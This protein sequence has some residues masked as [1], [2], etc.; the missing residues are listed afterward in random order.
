MIIA[1]P[2]CFGRR[3]YTGWGVSITNW[4]GA[5]Y[6]AG[7]FALLLLLLLIP[8]LTVEQRLIITGVWAMFMVVD[9]FRRDLGSE[10][11]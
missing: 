8:S 3:K 2:E 4:Q 11:R 9:M 7:I 5:V 6:L 1:K 10:K